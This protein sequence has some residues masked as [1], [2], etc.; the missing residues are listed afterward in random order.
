[1]NQVTTK[2]KNAT[3]NLVP[4]LGVSWLHS[5][6]N[7]I[8]M[9]WKHEKRFATVLKSPSRG[10]KTVEF[11]VAAEGIRDAGGGQIG[12]KRQKTQP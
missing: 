4:A 8:M 10:P 6:T 2:F 12:P 3:A 5:C 7:R 9:H 11:A 1:M